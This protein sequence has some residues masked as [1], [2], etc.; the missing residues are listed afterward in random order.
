MELTLQIQEM[1]ECLNDSEK[2]L[3]IEILKRFLSNDDVLSGQD[4]YY[5]DLA[6]Q[7]Y[8]NGETISHNDIDWS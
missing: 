4:M 2:V 8:I 7:E 6:E 3:I 1:V 5:I